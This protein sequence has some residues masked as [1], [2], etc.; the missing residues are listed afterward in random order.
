[1][2][3]NISK[4]E[5]K[6]FRKFAHRGSQEIIVNKFFFKK[7]QMN[8]Y[9]LP[10]KVRRRLLKRFSF[11]H[12]RVSSKYFSE[13]FDTWQL[14]S[15]G[16]GL[17]SESCL[18]TMRRQLRRKFGK[19]VLVKVNVVARVSI[20]EKA[21]HSRMGKGKGVKFVKK[22]VFIRPGVVILEVRGLRQ[23]VESNLLFKKVNFGVKWLKANKA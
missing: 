6:P 2:L 13:I 16:Y 11:F 21:N 19:L 12:K 17:L 23:E 3:V 15:V 1:M 7:N 9:F 22:V 8:L 18:E 14:I 10:K 5:L 20:Y 4:K